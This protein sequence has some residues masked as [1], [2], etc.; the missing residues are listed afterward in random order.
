MKLT[1]NEYGNNYGDVKTR[2][3]GSF[4]LYTMPH[5]TGFRIHTYLYEVLLV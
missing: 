4:K 1:S 5:L 3:Y 2:F